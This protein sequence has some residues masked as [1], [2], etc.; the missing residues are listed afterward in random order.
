[1]RSAVIGLSPVGAAGRRRGRRDVFEQHFKQEEFEVLVLTSSQRRLE[2]L[3][4][5]ARSGVGSDRRVMYLF[6]TFEALV[7]ANF[8]RWDWCDLGDELYEGVLYSHEQ[9]AQVDRRR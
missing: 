5:V 4:R 2:A 1:M 9:P 6:A 3:G 7:P 8:P